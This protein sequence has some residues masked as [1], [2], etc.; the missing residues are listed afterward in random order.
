MNGI[1][2]FCIAGLAG[3]AMA[4]QGTFN[5][6]AGKTIGVAENTLLVHVVGAVVMGLILVLGFGKGDWSKIGEIPFYGYFGGVL[7]AVIIFGVIYAM[8]ALGVGNATAAIILFQISMA[9][10]VDSFGLFGAEKIP[11][12]WWRILGLILLG[13]G[14]K[15][16]FYKT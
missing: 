12:S 5:T 1:F 6:A 13:V 9:L 4:L 7:S 15:F 11:F 8:T 14:T 2:S 10:I 3:A 16:V